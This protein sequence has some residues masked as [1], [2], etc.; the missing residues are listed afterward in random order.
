[1]AHSVATPAVLT[2]PGMLWIA[3]LATAAPTN[4][5][6]GS[7]FTDDPAAAWVP[8]GATEEGSTLSYETSVEPITVAE[9]FDPIR[10]STVSREGSIAFNLANYTLS[11]YN[12]AMNGGVAALTATSG[13]GATSLFTVEPVAPGSEVRCM[14]LWESTDRTV[15]VMLRQVIQGGAIESAFK[16][17][18][19]LAVIPC[20][21]R[22]EVPTAAQPFIMWGA[23]VSRG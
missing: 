17:A 21:F 16:K 15:R 8:L 10:W 12:R 22:M 3:V 5:V 9:F 7:V 14:I 19:A 20:T 23:G 18:P 1:M 11:N 2:D 6:A 13:T 4:T